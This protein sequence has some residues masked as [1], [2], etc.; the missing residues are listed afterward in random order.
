[1]FESSF[2]SDIDYP[3]DSPGINALADVKQLMTM[4]KEYAKA[5]KKIVCPAY[6][7]P[8]SL[9]NKKLAT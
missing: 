1:M 2:S 8:A 4:V 3:Q 7:G 6:K 5:V 9:K